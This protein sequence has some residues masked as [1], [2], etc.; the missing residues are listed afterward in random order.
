MY[1]RSNSPNSKTPERFNFQL[2]PFCPLFFPTPLPV[3]YLLTQPS[4]SAQTRFT[5]TLSFRRNL[6]IYSLGYEAL[7]KPDCGPRR[8]YNIIVFETKE[9]P[10]VRK[11]VLNLSLL[12]KF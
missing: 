1:L 3:T 6:L 5:A 4:S 12:K 11:V 10:I 7:P 2:G 8:G 9:N